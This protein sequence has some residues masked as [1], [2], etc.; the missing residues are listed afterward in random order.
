MK[1]CLSIILLIVEAVGIFFVCSN[2]AKKKANHCHAEVIIPEGMLL[3]IADEVSVLDLSID[4]PS[5]KASYIAIPAGCVVAP[6]WIGGSSVTFT[7][8]ETGN[9]YNLD[10]DYFIEQ[11]QLLILN[12]KAEA[13]SLR[14][15]KE[16]IFKGIIIG[17]VVSSSWLL[18]GLILTTNLLK[19]G[20]NNIL[21]SMHIILIAVLGILLSNFLFLEH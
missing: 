15:R 16:I 7:Y 18:I 1:K 5:E 14:H 8:E 17:I 21:F 2:I 4:N 13:E 20:K 11:E 9:R 10:N 19:K 12:E 3:T 6:V